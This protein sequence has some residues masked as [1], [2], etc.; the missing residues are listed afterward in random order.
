MS[1]QVKEKYSDLLAKDSAKSEKKL[2][3]EKHGLHREEGEQRDGQQGA[4]LLQ[5][6]DEDQTLSTQS[7]NKSA[8]PK[9]GAETSSRDRSHKPYRSPWLSSDADSEDSS[10]DERNPSRDR[11]RHK[12]HHSRHKTSSRHTPSKVAHVSAVRAREKKRR[13]SPPH[14]VLKLRRVA[15]SPHPTTKGTASTGRHNKEYVVIHG[16]KFKTHKVGHGDT[17][18]FKRQFSTIGSDESYRKVSKDNRRR[19]SY[20]QYKANLKRSASHKSRVG[21]RAT[22]AP[23]ATAH[24]SNVSGETEKSYTFDSQILKARP[25][26][27]SEEQRLAEVTAR[28]RART[29]AICPLTAEYSLKKMHMPARRPTSSQV[30]ANTSETSQ[31]LKDH[32]TTDPPPCSAASEAEST[33]TESSVGGEGKAKAVGY[34]HD[35]AFVPKSQRTRTGMTLADFVKMAQESVRNDQLLE[36]FTAQHA[37]EKAANFKGNV[38]LFTEPIDPTVTG[39]GQKTSASSGR[40]DGRDEHNLSLPPGGQKY[41][42]P[43]EVPPLSSDRAD[44]V[45][46]SHGGRAER[47]HPGHDHIWNGRD[48]GFWHQSQYRIQSSQLP[49]SK[50]VS[51]TAQSCHQAATAVVASSPGTQRADSQSEP[52]TSRPTP[53]E[54]LQRVRAKNK[55][56]SKDSTGGETTKPPDSVMSC[57]TEAGDARRHGNGIKRADIHGQQVTSQRK[58]LVSPP[59]SLTSP[60]KPLVSP[61][62]SLTSPAKPLVSPP[63]SLTSPAKPLTSPP[64]PVQN[65]S[66]NNQQQEEAAKDSPVDEPA[67]RQHSIWSSDSESESSDDECWCM[68]CFKSRIMGWHVP[69]V[70]KFAAMKQAGENQTITSVPEVVTA[71]ADAQDSAETAVATSASLKIPKPGESHADATTASMITVKAV[72]AV[73]ETTS[74][75]K[76]SQNNTETAISVPLE[77]PMTGVLSNSTT[78]TTM[79]QPLAPEDQITLEEALATLVTA[80]SEDSPKTAEEES[81]KIK[82]PSHEFLQ[83]NRK[84]AKLSSSP[85]QEEW[86]KIFLDEAFVDFR[87]VSPTGSIHSSLFGSSKSSEENQTDFS[88]DTTTRP[89]QKKAHVSESTQGSASSYSSSRSS[90]DNNGRSH[91]TRTVS[92]KRAQSSSDTNSGESARGTTSGT[93][94]SSSSLSIIGNS[95]RDDEMTGSKKR[96][97]SKS[98]TNSSK[99]E[100]DG[101]CSSTSS[102]SLALSMNDKSYRAGKMI[103]YKKRARSSSGTSSSKSGRSSTNTS[104]RKTLLSVNKKSHRGDKMNVSKKRARSTSDINSGKSGCGTTSATASLS[105]LTN[106]NKTHNAFYGG[107]KKRVRPDPDHASIEKTTRT[108]SSEQGPLVSMYNSCEPID[109]FA[110]DE[111][112]DDSDDGYETPWN[113]GVTPNLSLSRLDDGLWHSCKPVRSLSRPPPLPPPLYHPRPPGLEHIKDSPP[114]TSPGSPRHPSYPL[115]YGATGRS[116]PAHYYMAPYHRVGI[117]EHIGSPL[118]STSTCPDHMVARYQNYLWIEPYDWEGTDMR[119]MFDAIE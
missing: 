116:K 112:K 12:K 104:T 106:N 88:L 54:V 80:E 42:A 15:S 37:T 108:K 101:T 16:N 49:G 28:I 67:N 50:Q 97:Q 99:D 86:F 119:D 46:F 62:I 30:E 7:S 21:A 55:I 61:P 35:I 8:V 38:T 103:A 36:R 117:L 22:F 18:S 6:T 10:G 5:R 90:N 68:E 78:S 57:D 85:S 20:E 32:S 27:Q 58:P 114:P 74:A 44:R 26:S 9:R 40:P 110:P 3:K 83:V 79:T 17:G 1:K 47:A 92:K 82:T 81:T 24:T 25:L 109:F 95:R 71:T 98:D 4:A 89:G 45:R 75:E 84:S 2:T 23:F 111:K 87:P 31:H 100:R 113:F 66:D 70:D 13:P 52:L 118:Q 76:R 59:I 69:H 105:P 102:G 115:R 107:K 56:A 29:G 48:E 96:A 33:Q 77:T 64:T 93:T 19:I 11:R 39:S 51:G 94:T 41:T 91:K 14:V 72:S 63:I 65:A 53:L 34:G 43:P 73:T 60:A